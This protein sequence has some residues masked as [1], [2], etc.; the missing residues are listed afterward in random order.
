MGT[1]AGQGGRE[2]ALRFDHGWND[3][4]GIGVLRAPLGL[5]ILLSMNGLLDPYGDIIGGTKRALLQISVNS[6]QPLT[7]GFKLLFFSESIVRETEHFR[8]LSL[9]S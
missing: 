9:Q 6:H 7:N 5:R 1:G 8:S 3:G 4:A 2:L